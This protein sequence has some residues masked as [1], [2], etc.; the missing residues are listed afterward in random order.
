MDKN[1]VKGAVKNMEGKAQE[2]KGALTNS[3]KDRAKGQGKQVSGKV[4]EKVGKAKDAV[5]KAVK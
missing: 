4:Q 5:R 1:R 2:A 3:D